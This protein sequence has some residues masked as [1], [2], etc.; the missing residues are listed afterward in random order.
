VTTTPAPVTAGDAREDHAQRVAEQVGAV[1]LAAEL[2]LIG[3]LAETVRKTTGGVLTP[4]AA[5]QHL[6]RAARPVLTAA[7][8][9]A[10]DLLEEGM[11]AV[12]AWAS[13]RPFTA[14]PDY[15][16]LIAALLRADAASMAALQR[17]LDAAV[18]AADEHGPGSVFTRGGM[19][20]VLARARAAQTVLDQLA[21]RGVTG[22]VDAAGRRWD[23]ATYAETIT[24]QAVSEA[25]DTL[26]ARA[27]TRAGTDLV[28]VATTST[29]GTCPACLP[30]LG[31][32]LSLTGDTPGYPTLADAKA[33]GFR[34]PNCRC[35]WDPTGAVAPVPDPADLARAAAAYRVA[36]QRRARERAA[37]R[38][39]RRHQAA[40]TP[41]AKAAARR[42]GAARR[43]WRA[44]R[45][46]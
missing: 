7:L 4:R 34:H 39:Q 14:R 25:W 15:G 19:L 18:A 10:R 6:Q 44:Q 40:I 22:L 21:E 28:R 3:L 26:H 32:V 12:A 5:W 23:L 45:R 36:Q 43:Q 11:G 37:R 13:G 24:R 27:L 16:E 9:R 35:Y 42:D 38:E 46:G 1:Y 31:R 2:A 29:E 30:W 41:A 33:S 8:V 20:P 17:G